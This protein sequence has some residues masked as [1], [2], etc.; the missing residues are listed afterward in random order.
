MR[1]KNMLAT[2]GLAKGTLFMNVTF[3]DQ[4]LGLYIVNRLGLWPPDYI[5]EGRAPWI[6]V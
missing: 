6:G 5:K 2:L 1:H 3:H 4:A